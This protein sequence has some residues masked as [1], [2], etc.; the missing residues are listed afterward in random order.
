MAQPWLKPRSLDLEF[1]TRWRR[2]VYIK[3][4]RMERRNE[5]LSLTLRGEDH[6][7]IISYHSTNKQEITTP[8]GFL[9]LDSLQE[10]MNNTTVS[11]K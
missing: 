7:H 4:K 2:K 6:C 5:N 10:I 3:K 11:A 1:S 9:F 8:Q